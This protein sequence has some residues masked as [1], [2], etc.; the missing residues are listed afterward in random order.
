MTRTRL[1]G[2]PSSGCRTLEN[3]ATQGARSREKF[4]PSSRRRRPIAGR[5]D[6]TKIR[7]RLLLN[8]VP[9]LRGV[10]L[11]D[12]PA[13]VG[14]L[15]MNLL[16]PSDQ[17]PTIVDV[18]RR[19]GDVLHPR[20]RAGHRHPQAH[21]FRR[22]RIRTLQEPQAQAIAVGRGPAIGPAW[23]AV[24]LDVDTEHDAPWLAVTVGQSIVTHAGEADRIVRCPAWLRATD[25]VTRIAQ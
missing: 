14:Q 23:L 18:R 16:V 25:P 12:T 11:W 9:T 19:R 21:R 22:A 3:D 1:G 2:A 24:I 15:R 10:A 6:R 20:V 4:P 8:Q 13:R 7:S 5:R 17:V